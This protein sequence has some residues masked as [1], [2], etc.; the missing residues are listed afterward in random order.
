[1]KLRTVKK[2]IRAI[3]RCKKTPLLKKVRLDNISE[4]M[5]LSERKYERHHGPK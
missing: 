5:Y 1:M 4:M 3:A 2:A